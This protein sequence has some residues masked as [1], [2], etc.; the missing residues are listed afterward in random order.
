MKKGSI[1]HK[2][3]MEK[4]REKSKIFH[5]V[6]S[7]DSGKEVLSVLEEMFYEGTSIVP[8]DPYATH[9]REGAREVVIF[10]KQ[11]IKGAE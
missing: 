6:F 11:S 2:E 9:S 7:T 1:E 10:I 5:K 8:G 4:I 3:F